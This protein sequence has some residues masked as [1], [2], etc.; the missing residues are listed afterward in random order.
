MIGFLEML[1]YIY[2]VEIS[3]HV[4]LGLGLEGPP[5]IFFSFIT[6]YKMYIR[7]TY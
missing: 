6:W 2:Q 4:R 1:H 5:Q 7:P 3:F